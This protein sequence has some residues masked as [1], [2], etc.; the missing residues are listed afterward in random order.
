[1]FSLPKKEKKQVTRRRLRHPDAQIS[2]EFFEVLVLCNWK[3]VDNSTLEGVLLPAHQSGG[4]SAPL[5]NKA[6][7]F[8]RSMMFFHGKIS[9]VP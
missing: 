3:F 8:F 5:Q 6:T 1:M 7:C 4:K 2:T 9:I